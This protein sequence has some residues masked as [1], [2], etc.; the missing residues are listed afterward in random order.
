MNTH[1]RVLIIGGNFAGLAAAI[2]LRRVGI[3]ATVFERASTIRGIEAGV[4]IQITAMKALKKLGLVEQVRTITGSPIKAI[5]IKSPR[6]QLLATIPQSHV[7]LELG[8]PGYVVHRA[9]YIA[10]L[11]RQLE[12]NDIIQLNAQCTGFEQ[13]KDGVTVHFADGHEERGA[14][15]LGADGI[16]SVVRKQVLGDEPLRYAGYTAWR[17]MPIF[18]DASLDPTI[19]QQFSGEGKIFG[20]YPA[21]D[22]I[23]WFAGQKTAPG[24]NDARIGRKQ[25][26]LD[27]FK[28]WPA[29]IEALLEATEEVA[30]LR[31]D[32]YDRKPKEKHW[33]TGR[34]TLAGDAAHPTT[35]TLGQGA[36][37]AI[38]DGIVLAKELAL[39]ENL[40]DYVA[41][42]NA[43]RA[44]ERNR[45][46]RTTAIV[47]ESWQL[48][49][50][51]LVTNPL[52]SRIQETFL[53]MTPKSVW[54]KR[55]EADAM[56]E[57]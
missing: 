1:K 57:A 38:E 10:L 32:V 11:V 19:L 21:K 46:P 17:A 45:I 36:G 42:E 34:V 23:Y 7:G 26:L 54:R 44:Y 56:Y 55:G 15:L 43:L 18:I 51:V 9:E 24:G 40:D 28:G 39:A 47:N 14:V 4:V 33:G 31:N 29:P 13:D 25:E 20:V 37:M 2:A 8:T 12:G 5:D 35:P 53:K 3:D 52:R 41:V 27:L 50:T 30:I 22:K 16:H 49:N 48:S 6:G